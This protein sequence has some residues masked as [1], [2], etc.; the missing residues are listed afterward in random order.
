MT[1]DRTAS[2]LAFAIVAGVSALVGLAFGFLCLLLNMP[3]VFAGFWFAAITV[4]GAASSWNAL[5]PKRAR[6]RG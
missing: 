4:S 2:L 1:K 3:P 5:F 6:K